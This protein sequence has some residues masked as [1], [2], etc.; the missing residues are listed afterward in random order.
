MG[1]PVI[2]MSVDQTCGH[3]YTPIEFIEGSPDVFV[4]NKQVV[5]K[6]DKIPE[7]CCGDDCHQGAAIGCGSNVYANS[8]PIQVQTNGLDCGDTSCNGSPDVFANP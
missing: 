1:M 5:R 7:H 8:K 4:N 2:R 3:C 6:G